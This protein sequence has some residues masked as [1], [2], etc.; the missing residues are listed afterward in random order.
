[1]H[2]ARRSIRLRGFDYGAPGV[3]FVTLI[4]YRRGRFF[5]TL[6][7]GE[8][9]PSDLGRAVGRCW[10]EIPSHFPFV[11]L[12]AFVVM[13]DHVHGIV[14]IL[15]HKRRGA[16][17]RGPVPFR[18]LPQVL[19]SIV[20]GFKIGVTTWA[21]AHTHIQRISHRNYYERIVRDQRALDAIRRYISANP[22]KWR[23]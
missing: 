23:G 2:H 20:R 14:R 7:N 6:F 19:G 9:V 12:D 15:P 8:M 18:S 21:R 3:Y 1:M 10:H 13:P 4:T 22:A 5:G 11:E 17:T 16:P